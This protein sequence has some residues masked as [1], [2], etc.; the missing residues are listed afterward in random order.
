MEEIEIPEDLISNS[1]DEMIDEAFGDCIK[2]QEW[3]RMS[4]RAILAPKNHEVDIINNDIILNR[5]FKQKI[6][7]ILL[8]NDRYS[9]N[10]YKF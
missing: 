4:T 2:Q 6:K 5:Y 7:F 3:D 1:Y 10:I 9:Q 8:Q